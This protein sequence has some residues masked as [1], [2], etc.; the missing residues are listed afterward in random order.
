MALCVTTYPHPARPEN[1]LRTRVP[2]TLLFKESSQS[3][4]H[5]T[6]FKFINYRERVLDF[7]LPK[8]YFIILFIVFLTAS[9]RNESNISTAQLKGLF[10]KVT[11]NIYSSPGSRNLL[12]LL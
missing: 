2:S 5:F 12:N 8:V 3:W 1:T 4:T 11:W 7:W 9:V 6:L 10:C